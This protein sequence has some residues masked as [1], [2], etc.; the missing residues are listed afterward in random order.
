ML[1]LNY[2]QQQ[3]IKPISQNNEDKY[4]QI[5]SE[6]EEFELKKILGVRF[7]QD[8]QTT[9]SG[10]WNAKLL[11]G[12]TL[13]DGSKHKGLKYVIAYLNFSRYIGSS[14]VVDSFSGF[15]KHTTEQ[16]EFL[17]EGEVKRLLNLNREIA[18]TE[19]DLIKDWLNENYSEFPTW[20][21]GKE[22]KPFTPIFYGVRKTAR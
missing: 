22:K 13:K 18:L 5:A 15:K 10:T 9:P 20:D 2:S 12:D 7:L 1:L 8:I 14:N 16:S 11:T 21:S 6:V 17:T 4:F 3:N 19:F